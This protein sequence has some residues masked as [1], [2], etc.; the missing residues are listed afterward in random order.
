MRLRRNQ[1]GFTLLELLIVLGLFGVIV[2][3]VSTLYIASI[4]NSEDEFKRA[5]LT[6]ALT[7]A[8]DTLSDDIKAATAI[9][10]TYS[11]YTSGSQ[12]VVLDLPAVDSS[13]NI[14]YLGNSFVLDR[15]VYTYSSGVLTKS[16]FP[17]SGSSR[18]AVT[19]KTVLSK[20]SSLSFTYP[21][22]PPAG[23]SQMS[24]SITV[25]D[26]FKNRTASLTGYNTVVLRNF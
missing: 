14:I 19:N 6:E 8:T 1:A 7:L 2:T 15:V 22:S 10:A 20:I 11:T 18:S 5:Q 16:V 17:G 4:K 9:E 21:S 13:H 26:S 25:T 3:S 12:T 23:N 24:Y